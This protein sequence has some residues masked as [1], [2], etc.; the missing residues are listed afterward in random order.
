MFMSN[1]DILPVSK[2]IIQFGKSLECVGKFGIEN[3][4]A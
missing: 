4:D 1:Y 3:Q 2:D